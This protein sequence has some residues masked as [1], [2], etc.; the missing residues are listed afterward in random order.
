[1][2]L[3][4]AAN[5]AN[6]DNSRI[7]PGLV[8]YWPW[9]WAGRSIEVCYE[10]WGAG[11]EPLL[12][13]PALST[14]SSRREM[15]TIA[16]FLR[17]QFPDQ[18]QIIALDWPGF[19]D[20]DRLPL[21]YQCDLYQHFL[22]AFV[23]A[24]FHRPVGVIAAGHAAGYV[25]ATQNLATQNLWAKIVLVAP[26]WLGPFT[27][28]GLPEHWRSSLRSL[29]R[30]PILG[31]ALYALNTRPAFLKWMYRRHVFVD[32]TRLTDEFIAQRYANTQ[33]PGARYAPA[34]FV[35]GGLDPARTRED[36]L[37][38][39][40]GTSAPILLLLP[41]QAPSRSR[42]EMEAIAA[43]PQVQTQRLPGTLGLAEERG[44]EVAEAIARFL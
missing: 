20:S 41:E 26:T 22:Q 42:A 10:T 15:G 8:Q 9:T 25:M 16:H 7:A 43:L 17:Q 11:G 39:F 13:L 32:A 37:G 18:Y 33:R 4:A 27:A 31:Q 35:T 19:G 2:V 40:K 38:Y 5:V 23:N 36:F 44:D 1:M 21:S 24:Q 3:S 6:F 28:M 29:V 34:A 12:L 30:S 14:V